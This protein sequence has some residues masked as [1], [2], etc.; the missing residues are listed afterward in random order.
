MLMEIQYE[1]MDLHPSNLE[2]FR[3]D[4]N[5]EFNRNC[6]FNAKVRGRRVLCND[7]QCFDII[8]E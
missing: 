6:I 8:R 5:L 2:L 1:E 7:E 4:L 3:N